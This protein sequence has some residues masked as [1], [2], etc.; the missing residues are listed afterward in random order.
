MKGV[1]KASV[2]G[3]VIVFLKEEICRKVKLFVH[4]FLR[5]RNLGISSG[6]FEVL[7]KIRAEKSWYFRKA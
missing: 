2:S 6:A 5:L 7:K 1:L 4:R 3:I